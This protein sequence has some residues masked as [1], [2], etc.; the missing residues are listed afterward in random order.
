MKFDRFKLM[1]Q[2]LVIYVIN[3]HCRVVYKLCI[4]EG[5]MTMAY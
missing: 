2:I 1:E 5:L 3:F 4:N